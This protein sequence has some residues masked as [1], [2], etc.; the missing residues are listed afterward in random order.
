MPSKTVSIARS[1]TS[2]AID[3]D[4]V[5]LRRIKRPEGRHEN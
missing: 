3:R 1:G 4:V 5:P 2:L